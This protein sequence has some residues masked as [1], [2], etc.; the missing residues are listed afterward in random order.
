M[1][2]G[3]LLI[4]GKSVMTSGYGAAY[5]ENKHVYLP[6][7]ESPK[8]PSTRPV[9][10]QS[11]PAPGQPL[12]QGPSKAAFAPDFTRGK[13]D[14]PA[15]PPSG[16]RQ[17]VA[18]LNPVS[19]FRG[20]S[21]PAVQ[22]V[23]TEQSLDTVKVVYNDLSNAEVEVVPIKSRPAPPEE[24]GSGGTWGSLGAKFFRTTPV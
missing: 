14:R 5:R 11:V 15:S 4:S 22:A 8:S 12:R 7:F 9:P 24:T 10:V 16:Q 21:A 13:T 19:L 3:K 20:S 1:N 2:F 6:K 17:W 23:Q 18:K